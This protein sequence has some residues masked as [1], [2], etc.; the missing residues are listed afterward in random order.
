MEIK[1]TLLFFSKTLYLLAKWS[2]V[3]L[4]YDN[5]H[6]W[7]NGFLCHLIRFNMDEVM[8]ILKWLG[9]Y[10]LSSQRFK[11]LFE[12][13]CVFDFDDFEMDLLLLEDETFLFK[14]FYEIYQNVFCRC[15]G[16]LHELFLILSEIND[17]KLLLWIETMLVFFKRNHEDSFNMNYLK[18]HK[19]D[20][21]FL[22]VK[23]NEQLKHLMYYFE[24]YLVVD[25]DHYTGEILGLA[26]NIC[27][28]SY[29]KV[30]NNGLLNIY[31]HNSLFD[32]AVMI[33]KSIQ[34]SLDLPLFDM[35]NDCKNEYDNFMQYFNFSNFFF[36]A[37]TDSKVRIIDFN[38][39]I[40]ILDSY[41]LLN[42]SL[43]EATSM[44]SK[45]FKNDLICSSLNYF[46]K[47]NLVSFE[48]MNNILNEDKLKAC[49]TKKLIFP[50]AQLEDHL[51]E[52]Q[53][54]E[55]P[56]LKMFAQNYLSK[57]A[58]VEEEME[59]I[60]EDYETVKVIWKLFNIT[61]LK[62]LLHI[63]VVIDSLSLGA[64]LMD[65]DEKTFKQTGF[66]ILSSVSIFSFASHFNNW[67]SGVNI[68][69]PPSSEH[70]KLF[71]KAVRGGMSTSGSFR[72]GIDTDYYKDVLENNE[73][74][75]Q[76][77]CFILFCDE[78]SQYGAAQQKPLPFQ[79]N[80]YIDYESKNFDDLINKYYCNNIDDDKFT[81]DAL[82]HCKI[83]M[84]NEHQDKLHGYSPMVYRSS[85]PLYQYSPYEIIN[86]RKKL[87][88][89]KYTIEEDKTEKLL[90][91]V[92]SHITVESLDYLKWLVENRGV[93]IE[94][95]YAV[96]GLF[97]YPLS[98]K[99]VKFYMD[100][101][102]EAIKNKDS[103]TAAVCKFNVNG[104][105]G[106]HARKAE[107]NVQFEIITHEEQRLK[108]CV[109][110]INALYLNLKSQGISS[111]NIQTMLPR[112]FQKFFFNNNSFIFHNVD[113][114]FVDK[115][116][117]KIIFE[118]DKV[119]CARSINSIR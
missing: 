85:I 115:D 41:R 33:L 57:F 64:A 89:G 68:Q 44:L 90:M 114:I 107:K 15:N 37:N 74:Q 75:Q 113:T 97:R 82:I 17:P 99:T 24:N 54:K 84:K 6:F 55:I 53:H 10:F 22:S 1:D 7:K 42:M 70:H 13:G 65:F 27:N 109:E 93:V 78:N 52:M 66:H 101:R 95:I 104:Q 112:S 31:A 96:I 76:F 51:L 77:D 46:Y 45:K 60:R 94:E 38:H 21:E 19:T 81:T 32:N 9:L 50:Y 119:Q 80:Y 29:G 30:S 118:K 5:K 63:Y 103:I 67:L 25:H 69:H 108:N 48:N 62:D 28:V 87:K 26:H 61:K 117:K 71:E 106:F 79:M 16:K 116:Q 3:V 58:T 39:N 49:L 20:E 47:N 72:F 23:L 11:I 102:A 2:E 105:Y 59:N 40:R 35:D 4:K 110:N 73:I 56:P 34:K 43:N 12:Y 36:I 111:Q 100:M 86:L 91:K 98:A 83:A 8:S 18:D 92:G 88:N 14:T